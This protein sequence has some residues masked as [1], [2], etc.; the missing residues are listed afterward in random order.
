M[1]AKKWDCF[2]ALTE[3]FFWNASQ[4]HRY[5][6]LDGLHVFT[7]GPLANSFEVGEKKSHAVQDQVNRKVIPIQQCPSQPGTDGCSAHSVL[8]L[9][10]HAQIFCDNLLNIVQLTCDLLNSQLMI[11]IQQLLFL[12]DIALSLTCWRPPAPGVFFHL[13]LNLSCYL[14]TFLKYFKCLWQFS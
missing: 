9:F 3:G 5:G 2:Y 10:R 8:L 13:R 14:Y 7:T 12:L 4:F 1:S 11:A 6:H